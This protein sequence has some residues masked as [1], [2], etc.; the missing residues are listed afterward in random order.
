MAECEIVFDSYIIQG[1]CNGTTLK[2]YISYDVSPILAMVDV[3][4]WFFPSCKANLKKKISHFFPCVVNI[5]ANFLVPVP[6]NLLG[7]PYICVK[8]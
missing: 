5:Q 8:I 7:I 4:F 3:I 6:I 1:P 2:F